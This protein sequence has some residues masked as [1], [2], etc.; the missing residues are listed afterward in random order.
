MTQIYRRAAKHRIKHIRNWSRDQYLDKGM[1]TLI[2]SV[3]TD[4]QGRL[5]GDV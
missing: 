2:F 1:V 4:L 3:H 5:A